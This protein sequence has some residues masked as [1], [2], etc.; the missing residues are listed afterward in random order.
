MC[1][2]HNNR[3]DDAGS[4]GSTLR[5]LAVTLNA[6]GLPAKRTN[7]SFH[8]FEKFIF[9]FFFKF[10]KC[11]NYIRGREREREREQKMFRAGISAV[12]SALL[13]R[14]SRCTEAGKNISQF[15]AIFLK[16]YQ[17]AFRSSPHCRP[18]VPK[19]PKIV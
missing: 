17:Y 13:S 9:I 16:S 4:P 7:F 1:T 12:L 2:Q 5:T 14:C 8:H 6:F 10:T 11:T 19:D 18:A 3:I 15:S